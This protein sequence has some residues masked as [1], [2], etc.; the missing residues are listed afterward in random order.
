MWTKTNTKY[1][2]I[3]T[4]VQNN[5]VTYAACLIFVLLIEIHF[6]SGAYLT[7]PLNIENAGQTD[8]NDWNVNLIN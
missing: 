5:S 7:S 6:P 2:W 8:L 3:K 1:I 4:I